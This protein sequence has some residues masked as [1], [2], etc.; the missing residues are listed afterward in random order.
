MAEA[1]GTRLALVQAPMAGGATTAQLVAAVSEAGGLGSLGGAMLSPDDLRA[2]IRAI[3]ALT[4]RPFGVNLFG[5]QPRVAADSAAAAAVREVLAPARA[6][7]GLPEPEPPQEWSSPLERQLEVVVEERV[8]AFSFT[9]SI[10][11]LDEVRESGAVVLGSATTVAE[12]VA[13][14]QAGVDIVVAQGSEAGGHRGTFLGPFEQG[15]VGGLA[16]VPQVVDRVSVPVIAAGGIMDGRGIAAALA[17]GAEGVQLG[18]AFLTCTESG[19]PPA[20]KAA[21]SAA[22]SDATVVTDAL[23]GRPARAIR[24]RLADELAQA[25]RLPYPLQ[26]AAGRDVYAA[27]AAQGRTEYMYLLSG[28]GAPM[29]RDL[30]AAELVAALERETAEAIERLR[31]R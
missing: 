2:A 1:L 8:P 26:G 10:P 21:L 19:A 5:P 29:C 24:N 20:G 4:D 22:G 13:L 16:L 17:L 6:D 30:S 23:S 7:L 15:L 11:P 28:Q 25:Q 9:F 18:T 27:A 12:A 31:A 14:E 3:R